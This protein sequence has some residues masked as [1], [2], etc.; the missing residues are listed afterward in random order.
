MGTCRS[1]LG[2]WNP[3]ECPSGFLCWN[4]LCRLARGGRV[5]RSPRLTLREREALTGRSRAASTGPPGHAALCRRCALEMGS[6]RV[7]SGQ[8]RASRVGE[9]VRSLCP[10]GHSC[11]TSD[12]RSWAWRR[13]RVRLDLL[14]TQD[15]TCS[16]LFVTRSEPDS[17]VGFLK[18]MLIF[19]QLGKS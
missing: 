10:A 1:K 13:A 5:L 11:G 9:W 15:C 16:C 2:C 7:G 14:A 3:A 18:S 17:R 19:G 6:G 8:N 12:A 4:L